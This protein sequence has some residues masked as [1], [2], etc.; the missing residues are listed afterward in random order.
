MSSWPTE[1]GNQTWLL[2]QAVAQPLLACGSRLLMT[3]YVLAVGNLQV[4][5]H[6]SMLLH[7][8][9]STQTETFNWQHSQQVVQQTCDALSTVERAVSTVFQALLHKP[10]AF[11]PLA[12]CFEVFAFTL[13]PDSN[14]KLWLLHACPCPSRFNLCMHTCQEGALCLVNNS[15]V[16]AEQPAKAVETHMSRDSADVVLQAVWKDSVSMA[17]SCLLHQGTPQEHNMKLILSR[18]KT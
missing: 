14:G 11:L 7:P 15:S 2:Q 17:A 10:Q 16:H 3:A 18:T 9:D 13:Q 6:R 5:L 1:E 4:Y 8:A 12:K